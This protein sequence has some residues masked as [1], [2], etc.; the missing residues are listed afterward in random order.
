MNPITVFGSI[1]S[2]LVQTYNLPLPITICLKAIAGVHWIW[3]LKRKKEMVKSENI[4]PAF[5]G[6]G[7]DFALK[8]TPKGIEKTI[9]AIA[10]LI[11]IATRIDEC[12]QRMLELSKEFKNLKNAI[13]GIKTEVFEYE[14]NKDNKF[15]FIPLSVIN[16]KRKL[17][18]TIPSY[19]KRIVY[20]ILEIFKKIFSLSMHIWDTY[21]AF[22]L[23]HD[24][25]P[26][27][28][29]N[30]L[31]WYRKIH[32]NKEY[33]YEKLEDYKPF[34][35]KIFTATKMP[36]RLT[37]HRMIKYT[38]KVFDSVDKVVGAVDKANQVVGK[39]ITTTV[40]KVYHLV[41]NK[42]YAITS[43]KLTIGLQDP[44]IHTPFILNKL[45]AV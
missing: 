36:A 22:T 31:K 29:V 9:R 38:K 6:T 12:L 21:H 5:M 23:S 13:A 42:F 28:F 34:I 43:E 8:L 45:A 3:W 35:Q 15:S 33:F 10:K 24:D 37:A 17:S 14:W 26:E 11:L 25:V 44:K 1:K 41:K 40:K 39:K 18:K 20:S 32:D 16:K 4:I 7:L 2:D 27:I 30:G 19:F